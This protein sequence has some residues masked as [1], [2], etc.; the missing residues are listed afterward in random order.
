MY[1]LGQTVHDK[2]THWG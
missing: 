1:Q 2:F